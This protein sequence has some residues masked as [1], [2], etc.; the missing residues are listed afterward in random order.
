MDTIFLG[1][2]QINSTPLLQTSTH[3]HTST[4]TSTQPQI[5]IS[6]VDFV[7]II[8]SNRRDCWAACAIRVPI[9]SV[10]LSITIRISFFFFF[11]FVESN[12]IQVPFEYRL[13]THIFPHRFYVQLFKRL[14]ST[15]ISFMF[16]CFFFFNFLLFFV[17]LFRR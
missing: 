12:K 14:F 5:H 2:F 13:V 4:H 8:D 7:H 3:T 9:H 15:I 10:V 6:I 11:A 17:S 16:F 1:R